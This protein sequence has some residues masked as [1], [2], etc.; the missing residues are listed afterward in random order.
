MLSK[1]QQR[2][3]KRQSCIIA[4]NHHHY[5]KTRLVTTSDISE[6]T[7]PKHII[8]IKL[9]D[10]KIFYTLSKL[11]PERNSKKKEF[12]NFLNTASTTSTNPSPTYSAMSSSSSCSSSKSLSNTSTSK[13]LTDSSLFGGLT[14]NHLIEEACT[15]LP[16]CSSSCGSSSESSFSISPIITN[17]QSS[18]ITDNL[19]E[20]FQFSNVE[21]S[22][23]TRNFESIQKNI[24]S[25]NKSK[26]RTVK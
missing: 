23:V 6:P 3:S 25:T 24:L 8:N 26:Q 17:L 18:T 19:K 4:E 22:M 2:S 12:T 14:H 5:H 11:L 13:M 1:K 15:I 7:N 10:K 9:F 21:N 20:N 16:S